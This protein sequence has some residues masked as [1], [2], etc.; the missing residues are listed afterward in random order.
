[1]TVAAAEATLHRLRPAHPELQ[2]AARKE[3]ILASIYF[4]PPQVSAVNL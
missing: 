2:R 3:T 4:S 1:M